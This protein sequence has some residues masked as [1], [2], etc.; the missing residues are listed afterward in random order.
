MTLVTMGTR[1]GGG[2]ND[3][4]TPPALGLGQLEGAGGPGPLNGMSKGSLKTFLVLDYLQKR[5]F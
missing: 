1:A 3:S 4:T 5:V 2:I